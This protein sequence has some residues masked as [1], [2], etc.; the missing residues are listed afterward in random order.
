MFEMLQ[1]EFKPKQ[2][3]FYALYL[4]KYEKSYILNDYIEADHIRKGRSCECKKFGTKKEAEEWIRKW[5]I[6]EFKQTPKKNFYGIYFI[7]EKAGVIC[8]SPEKV[9]QILYKVPAYCKKFYIEEEAQEWIYALKNNIIT[10]PFKKEKKP[11]QK[12]SSRYYALYFQKTND[13]IIL[14]TRK[15]ADSLSKGKKCILKKFSDENTAQ[16]WIDIMVLGRARYFAVFYPG[17]KNSF[18]TKDPVL[19]QEFTKDRVNINQIFE[20]AVEADRWIKTM[21]NSSISSVE[22]LD[23]DA[24]YFDAGTGR[25]IGM[26]VRVSDYT[27]NSLLEEL[28]EYKDKINEFGNYNLGE[29][30][31]IQYGELYGLYLALMIAEQK[32]ILKIAG[33]NQLVLSFWSMGNYNPKK[34]NDETVELIEKVV[35]LRKKFS[36]RGGILFYVR[37]GKN[38]AD[39]G[40]H[41]GK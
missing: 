12:N 6:G 25:K 31:K 24:V 37:G 15:E 4:P 39:L 21:E 10:E 26:E 33:D 40:F 35:E 11:K 32:N 22:T 27:G 41:R 9:N 5:K 1:I 17:E 16:E 30:L 8:E 3:V 36:L 23:K 38:P 2:Q 28:C 34:L 13:G 20:T 14:Q 19:F 18:I 29:N 7:D